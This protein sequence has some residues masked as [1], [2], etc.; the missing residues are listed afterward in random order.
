MQVLVSE[1]YAVAGEVLAAG[2]E[3]RALGGVEKELRISEHPFGLGAE[4]AG[5]GDGVAEVHVY[6]HDGGEGPVY[7]R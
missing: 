1:V 3:A 4:G 2:Y 7:A 6:V 5:V